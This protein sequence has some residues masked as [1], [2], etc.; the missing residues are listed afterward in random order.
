VVDDGREDAVAGLDNLVEL[1]EL[2]AGV[3]VLVH[4]GKVDPEIALGHARGQVSP[5]FFHALDSQ[6]EL[7]VLR[8]V[9]VRPPVPALGTVIAAHPAVR[10][11]HLVR[12]KLFRQMLVHYD[13][14]LLRHYLSGNHL[15]LHQGLSHRCR[16]FPSDDINVV[17]YQSQTRHPHIAH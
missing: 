17:I 2:A 9:R 5:R 7:F 1:L 10:H 4:A 11:K 3:G 6:L 16:H 15:G 8:I 13:L 12:T 14:Q